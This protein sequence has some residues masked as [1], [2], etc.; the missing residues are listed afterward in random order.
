MASKIIPHKLLIGF[1]EDGTFK[2]GIL[3]YQSANDK[4]EILPKY[5]TVQVNSEISVP[6]MNGIIQKAITFA[7]NTEGVKNA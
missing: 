4:G 1:N 2:D 6:V 5:N 7:K 3:I